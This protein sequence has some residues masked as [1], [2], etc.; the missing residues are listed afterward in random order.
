MTCELGLPVEAQ[1]TLRILDRHLEGRSLVLLDTNRD[2]S[3]QGTPDLPVT[4]D[5]LIASYDYYDAESD[6]ESGSE[7][8]WYKNAELQVDLNNSLTVDSSLT[9]KGQE[10]NFTVTPSDS[11]EFGSPVTSSTV[12]INNSPPTIDFYSP[13]ET[14]MEI[15]E[16]ESIE[17]T[18]TSSD[19]DNDILTYSWTLDSDEVASTQ[20]WTYFLDFWSQGMHTIG[21]NVT[22]TGELSAY[23]EWNVNV[24]NVQ[25]QNLIRIANCQS[26]R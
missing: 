12:T 15:N 10:W 11:T 7:I 25:Y 5:D 23:Q 3:I 16:G 8:L 4:S 18:H 22:D 24:L 13:A 6:P 20:N 9:S 17:F 2:V 26:G 1:G 21:I 14:T 19:L